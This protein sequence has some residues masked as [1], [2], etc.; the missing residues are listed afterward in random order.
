MTRMG[1]AKTL[2]TVT[3]IF[4]ANLAHA[5]RLLK[6]FDCGGGGHGTNFTVSYGGPRYADSV[7][8]NLIFDQDLKL[9]LSAKDESASDLSLRINL[10][11]G[12]CKKGDGNNV[13][14]SCQLDKTDKI[15]WSITDFGFTSFQNLGNGFH[16]TNS[17]QRSVNLISM[18]LKVTREGNSAHLIADL[19]IDTATQKNINLRLNRQLAT[20][21]HSWYM[22]KF[23]E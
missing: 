1:F 22:C 19:Q 17:V 23:S 10:S 16:E 3:L 20:L 21:E 14:V 5:D 4:T 12:S 11:T 9:L 7:D 6:S 18:D 2:I 15:S 13:L 8:L